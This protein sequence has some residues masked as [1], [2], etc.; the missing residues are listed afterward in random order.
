MTEFAVFD[1]LRINLP[2]DD[3]VDHLLFII[4]CAVCWVSYRI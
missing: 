1:I 4:D 3:L 2:G